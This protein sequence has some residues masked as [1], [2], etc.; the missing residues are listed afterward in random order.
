MKEP[1]KLFG[2][3]MEHQIEKTEFL[4]NDGSIF[5]WQVTTVWVD[6][7]DVDW[8]RHQY[9]AW[10]MRIGEGYTEAISGSDVPREVLE[11]QNP[12]AV[13]SDGVLVDLEP[14]PESKEDDF[15]EEG[16][17]VY[18]ADDPQEEDQLGIAMEDNQDPDKIRPGE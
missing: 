12:N 14:G 1:K 10:R 13:P 16:P 7:G 3:P 4:A 2:I 11:A 5:V 9:E 8:E 6:V 17:I 15:W 18:H